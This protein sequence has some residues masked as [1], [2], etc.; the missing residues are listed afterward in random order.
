MVLVGEI[1]TRSLLVVCVLKHW[2]NGAITCILHGLF[3]PIFS[4]L[5]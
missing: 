3:A 4:S 1:D 5:G 2:K